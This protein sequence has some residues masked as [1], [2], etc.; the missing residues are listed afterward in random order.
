[1]KIPLISMLLLIP[2]QSFGACGEDDFLRNAGSLVPE[3]FSCSA[4]ESVDDNLR[5]NTYNLFR[6]KRADDVINALET[7]GF[8]CRDNTCTKV[9]RDRESNF[10]RWFGIRPAVKAHE[11]GRRYWRKNTFA[12]T[13]NADIITSED[14][15]VADYKLERALV[16]WPLPPRK[17]DY[18]V[19]H[20]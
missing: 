6:D 10:D 7:Q 9:L 13:L 14:D 8:Q 2:T 16:K 20:D 11:R 19:S 4:T 5:F 15:I 12:V 17:S 3:F 1:M 18:K